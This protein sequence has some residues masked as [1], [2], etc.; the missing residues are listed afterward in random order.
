MG[1]YRRTDSETYWMSAR[2]D[3][4]RLGK[5][6]AVR[7]RKAAEEIYAAWMVQLARERCMGIVQVKQQHTVAQLLAE[8]LAKVAPLKSMHS[9]RRDRMVLKRFTTRWG[10]LRLDAVSS[11]LIEDYMAE[12]MTTVTLASV[13]KELG[14]LKSAFTRAMRWEW[15]AKSPFR[16]ITLNQEGEERLRWLTEAEEAQLLAA[17]PPWLAGYH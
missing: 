6:R 7:Q 10:T 12:R 9:Q 2:M 16:G 3:G 5:T 1:V 13:S 11:K 15:I 4:V 17:C 8:Y 14:I